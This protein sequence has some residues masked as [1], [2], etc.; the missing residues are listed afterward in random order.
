MNAVQTFG[1]LIDGWSDHVGDELARISVPVGFDLYGKVHVNVRADPSQFVGIAAEIKSKIP[2]V[3]DGI[4]VTKIVM[5]A[6]RD[7]AGRR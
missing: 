6:M 3:L 7:E 5:H 2:P 4:T 1:A